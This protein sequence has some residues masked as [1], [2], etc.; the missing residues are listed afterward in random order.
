[1]LEK[2]VYLAGEILRAPPEVL[3]P[4]AIFVLVVLV[5]LVLPMAKRTHAVEPDGVDAEARRWIDEQIDEYV[6]TLAEAYGKVRTHAEHDELP[7]S[8]AATIES[9]IAEVLLR[10]RDSEDFDFD[11]GMAVREFVVLHREQI[12]E[13][14]AT[15]IREHLAS[16]RAIPGLQDQAP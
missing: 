5:G 1:M 7:P 15:R 10:D 6:D 3:V 11:L 14:V 12:Y 13:D 2:I 16:A 8:F 4:A 9:F